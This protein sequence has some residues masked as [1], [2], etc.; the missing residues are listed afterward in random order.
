MSDS[1]NI[2]ISE[3]VEAQQR[4]RQISDAGED[5]EAQRIRQV[6]DASDAE[7][8]DV[9]AQGVRLAGDADV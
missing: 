9:E 6:S 2:N 8:D 5:T 7:D 4:I 1:E 3:D